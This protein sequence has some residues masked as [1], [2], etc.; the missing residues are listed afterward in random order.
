MKTVKRHAG[1]SG[2]RKEEDVVSDRTERLSRSCNKGN[3]KKSYVEEKSDWEKPIRKNAAQPKSPP[4]QKKADKKINEE[5]VDEKKPI[6]ARTMTSSNNES[7][8][9]YQVGKNENEKELAEPIRLIVEKKLKT[10]NNA[11]NTGNHRKHVFTTQLRDGQ[12]KRLLK[13]I[14]L[15]EPNSKMYVEPWDYCVCVERNIHKKHKTLDEYKAEIEERCKVICKEF[16]ETYDFPVWLFD[17][18]K[19]QPILLQKTS[20]QYYSQE[21]QAFVTSDIREHMI[22]LLKTAI[23]YQEEYRGQSELIL[24]PKLEY[25]IYEKSSSRYEYFTTIAKRVSQM[26][27][28]K[29]CTW[30]GIGFMR[31][32]ESTDS[33]RESTIEGRVEDQQDVAGTEGIKMTV[34]KDGGSSQQNGN[35]TVEKES[36]KGTT[37]KLVA[38]KKDTSQEHPVVKA[39]PKPVGQ[40]QPKEKVGSDGPQKKIEKES[41]KRKAEKLI[42][43]KKDVPQNVKKQVT[44]KKPA[45]VQK[46]IGDKKGEE[47]KKST[48]RPMKPQ[49]KYIDIDECSEDESDDDE[50][51]DEYEPLNKKSVLGEIRASE[52]KSRGQESFEKEI[53]VAKKDQKRGKSMNTDDDDYEMDVDEEEDAGPSTS[54][55]PIRKRHNAGPSEDAPK[56]KVRKNCSVFPQ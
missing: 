36:K 23:L 47:K 28:G 54:S 43:S 29:D 18:Y 50:D 37:E 27:E 13:A 8:S 32:R 33:D 1:S 40:Q 41:Q 35:E 39:T 14:K 20:I 10:V 45:P 30:E 21:W 15:K 48:A 5:K 3:N 2:A 46:S 4:K 34:K 49:H 25:P 51:D 22:M 7:D 31:R 16:E 24:S 53:S 38:A 26:L 12:I 52:R 19:G 11:S 9:S 44:V 17:T 6:P 42:A 55:A 56:Q